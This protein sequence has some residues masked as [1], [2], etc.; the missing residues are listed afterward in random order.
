[1]NRVEFQTYK[2]TRFL[3]IDLSNL[4]TT[5]VQPV[6]AEAK[7]V[8][9]QQPEHSVLTLTDITKMGFD[10]SVTAAMKE[11]VAHNTP[12]VKASA[13]V[14]AAGLLGIV[15]DGVER[16]ATRSLMNFDDRDKA[17]EWLVQQ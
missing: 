7:R 16:A 1:M 12:Y 8:I 9:A 2:G 4:K 15:K 6:I 13:V 10:V 14:G 5:E 11:Y 17:Q 3:L